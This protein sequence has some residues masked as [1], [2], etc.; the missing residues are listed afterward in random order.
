MGRNAALQ[1]ILYDQN[2]TPIT[3]ITDYANFQWLIDTFTLV[4][5]SHHHQKTRI[6]SI[7]DLC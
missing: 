3:H 2:H 1:A 4:A 7:E 6:K 5:R